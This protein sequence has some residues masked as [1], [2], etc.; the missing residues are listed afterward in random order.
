[1]KCRK[2]R[3]S[4]SLYKI[5]KFTYRIENGYLQ[6]S[7]YSFSLLLYQM[8]IFSDFLAKILG[9]LTKI[10]NFKNFLWHIFSCG[11]DCSSNLACSSNQTCSSNQVC[12]S[13]Q[14]SGSNQ[15]CSSNQACSSN[16]VCGS[17]QMKIKF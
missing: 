6:L 5:L 3:D 12:S 13:N 8:K 9:R 11:S 14:E 4:T 1:M 10:L 17:N 15:V 16:Q 2:E 7:M